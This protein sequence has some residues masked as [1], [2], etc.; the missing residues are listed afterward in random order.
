MANSLGMIDHK[1]TIKDNI[2]YTLWKLFGLFA[3]SN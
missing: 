1:M 2:K 3:Y